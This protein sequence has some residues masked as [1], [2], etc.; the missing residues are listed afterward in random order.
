MNDIVDDMM[1][2]ADAS[3]VSRILE[4]AGDH[5]RLNEDVDADRVIRRIFTPILLQP[6]ERSAAWMLT[7]LNENSHFANLPEEVSS[8]L[9]ARMHT[10]LAKEGLS[11]ALV[12]TLKSI[13]EKL[14]P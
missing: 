2:S 1:G 5:I 11:E 8:E 7:A 9:Q 10:A 4:F 3:A 13:S 12:E 14:G 6:S